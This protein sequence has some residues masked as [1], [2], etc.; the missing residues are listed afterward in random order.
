[1]E[2]FWFQHRSIEFEAVRLDRFCFP[3]ALTIAIQ[4]LCAVLLS[5]LFWQLHVIINYNLNVSHFTRFLFI[6]SSSQI[7]SKFKKA[8]LRVPFT[9]KTQIR[10][11]MSQFLDDFC[12]ALHFVVTY[13]CTTFCRTYCVHLLYRNFKKEKLD[14]F[15]SKPTN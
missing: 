5:H 9:H 1:M 14:N 15:G 12:P 3:I 8:M 6:L 7:S 10:Y 11:M 13:M 4:N 2:Q